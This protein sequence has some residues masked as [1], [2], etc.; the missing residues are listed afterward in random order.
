LGPQTVQGETVW[1]TA[2]QAPTGTGTV[3][4][5]AAVNAGGTP[6]TKIGF[7][8]SQHGRT[9]SGS[10]AVPGAPAPQT[11]QIDGVIQ[12]MIP[13]WVVGANP[14]TD[15]AVNPGDTVVW[16]A[17]SGTHGVVFDT[18]AVAKAF[19]TF[20]TGGGLP[21]PGPQTVQGEMVWGTAPQAP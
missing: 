20:E 1:G 7:F 9:M 15:V 16:R 6:G 13:T 14:A 11:V 17:V 21:T 5:R 3:L 4:G 8:C 10:L 18:E 19:L 2:P 12:N